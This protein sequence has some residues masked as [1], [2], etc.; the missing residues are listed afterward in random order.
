[1]LRRVSPPRS[2]DE[3]GAAAIICVLVALVAFTFAALTVDLGNAVARQGDTQVQ[4]DFGALA[5]APLLDGSNTRTAT[6]PAVAE[7][8]EYMFGN[9]PRDDDSGYVPP[10]SASALAGHLVDS[11]MT[12]G[13]VEFLAGGTRMRV[14]GPETQVNF[15]FAGIFDLFSGGSTAKSVQVK[16]DATVLTGT[17][18]GNGVWPMYVANPT[19]GNPACDYGLQTLTDPPG[20]QVIP[21]SVPALN[22]DTDTNSNELETITLT[23]D[24]NPATTVPLGST[25]AQ[26][27]LSKKFADATRIGF[28]RSNDSSAGPV[29]VER[30]AWTDPAGT[31]PYTANNGSVTVPVPTTVSG[32][33]ILWYVRVFQGGT[34][35]KWSDR[36]EALPLSVGDAPYECV[37]GSSS[38]NF[39]TIKLPR[40][41]S[42]N[43]Q[44][45]SGW[46]PRN[47]ALGLEAPLSL[48]KF[49][50]DPPP[51]LCTTATPE[52]VFSS[53]GSDRKAYTNCVDTDTGLTSNTATP[54]FISGGSGYVGLL[55]SDSSSEDPDGSGGCSRDGDTGSADLPGTTV[56]VNDDLLTCFMTDETTQI[57]DVAR[58]NYVGGPKFD[59]A[60]YESPRFGWVPVFGEEAT[61]GGSQKYTIVDFRGA[62][63]TDQPMTA[64]KTT[65][66]YNTGTVN[67]LG[68][69]GSGG[70]FKLQTLKVVFLHPDSLPD[71]TAETPI[72]PNLGVGPIVTRLVD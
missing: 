68:V 4:V 15:G 59:P 2:Q 29:V 27:T 36:A 18:D 57:D 64:T 28:F 22:A 24:G 53:G 69:T 14:T 49:P 63:I 47:I 23:V 37:G 48:D 41:D 19:P 9:L 42:G 33:G 43:Q 5:G 51:T 1:V 71:G 44:N 67:G 58:R 61:S 50:G 6:D 45:D 39:G 34:T 31:T 70:G 54:G 13:N 12:N 65:N 32:D 38:G 26:I 7:V 56:D 62:F 72:G 10:A 30:T 55:D 25:T 40:G 20:G 66:A 11:D 3:H 16:S 21:P 46:I 52:R 35:N 8:A 17:P 60:I